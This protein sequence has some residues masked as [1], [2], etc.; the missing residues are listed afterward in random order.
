MKYLV[1]G[2]GGIGCA[3]GAYLA[4]AGKDAA[5]IA[6]GEQLAA[7]QKN[8]LK[9]KTAKLGDIAIEKMKAYAA[10][11]DFGK[12]DV[13]FVCVKGYSLL[14]TVSV[15]KK[16]SHEGT[17]VIPILNSLSAGDKL[18]AALPGVCVTGGCVYTS[19]FVSAPGEVTQPTPLFRIVFGTRKGT[20][21]DA[22]LLDKIAAELNESGI[23]GVNS[24]DIER[25]V[26][27]KFTFISAFATTDTFFDAN[28]GELQKPGE[29]RG[30]FISLL[31]ELND[32]AVAKG[33]N[34]DIDLVESSVKMLDGFAPEVMSSMHRDYSAGKNTEKQ[35]LIFDV[36]EAAK[37]LGVDVPAY[38]NAAGF[39]GYKA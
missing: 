27:K 9:A 34:M 30:M 25:D 5:L 29:G 23:E 32:V 7:I 13:I 39:F 17:V 12:V 6:R 11:D 16:A 38:E 1:I 35:E 18:G 26:F 3:I 19:A 37:S 4:N 28:I 2:A 14:E 31:T 20:K 24:S 21:A 36:V 10:E 8:G 33:L 15:I 22:A